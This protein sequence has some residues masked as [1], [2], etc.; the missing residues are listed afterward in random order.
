MRGPS[1]PRARASA[2]SAR[3]EVDKTRKRDVQTGGVAG[4]PREATT[5]FFFFGVGFP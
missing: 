4:S 5:R 3:L 2:S 1:G